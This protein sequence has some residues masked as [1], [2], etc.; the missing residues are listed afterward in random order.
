M[1]MTATALVADPFCKEHDTGY[2]HPETA[3]RFDAVINGLE[4][5]GLLIKLDCLTPR[6]A[7][8]EDLTLVH[9]AGYLELAEREIRAGRTQLST[10]DTVVCSKSWEAAIRAAGCALTAVDAVLSG[11]VARA[12]CA[13]RPPGHHATRDC[14]MGFC[15]VNNIAIAARHAQ[16]RHGIQRVLIVDW[17]V[18]HGNG[19]QDIFYDDPSVF[20]FSSHQSP[21]YPGTGAAHEIGAGE[22]KGAT[23]NCPLPAGAGRDEVFDAFE[24]KL[25]PA[26][27]SFRPELILISAGFDSRVKD[28]LGH[29]RLEDQDFADLT[30]L[31]L[32]LAKRDAQGRVISILEGGYNIAGLANAAAAHVAA[33]ME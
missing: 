27:D 30:R 8:L 19:T 3:Q 9:D 7:K 13:V 33:L 16:K 29:M 31:L 1:V 5:A 28:P 17:D 4:K 11:K 20:F 15:I 23:L 26:M 10:G 2:G 32:G 12:F 18:H 24:N 21:W 6:A 25:L 14:G 22:G